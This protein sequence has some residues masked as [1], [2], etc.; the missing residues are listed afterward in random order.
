M[1]ISTSNGWNTTTLNSFL[2][3]KENRFEIKKK[4]YVNYRYLHVSYPFLNNEKNDNIDID[5]DDEY[6]SDIFDYKKK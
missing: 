1:T 3:N 2:N 5:Y 4:Y 6:L